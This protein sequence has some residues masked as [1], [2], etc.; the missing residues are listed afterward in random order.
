MIDPTKKRLAAIFTSVVVVFNVLILVLSF[1]VLHQSL[2]N[3]VKRHMEED[4]RG[5]FLDQYHRSGLAPLKGMWDENRF[6]ILNV[7]G[8]II[9]STRNSA[10]FYPELN[11]R[12]LAEAFAG[13]QGFETRIVNDKA[14]LIT[15]FPLD[16]NYVGRA[17][18]S[19]SGE[20]RHARNFLKMIL[21][22]SPVMLLLSY[23]VSRYLLNHAMKPI[24]DIVT[25]QETFSSNVTHELRSPLASIKGNFEVALR[26]ERS[27]EEYKEVIQSGLRDTDR[28][29]NLLNNLSLLA[30]SKFKPLALYKNK[31]DL[32]AIFR[33]LVASYAPAMNARRIT[34]E[35]SETPG[36][37]CIC[38]EDLIRRTMENLVDNA[39]KYT[40][41]GGTIRLDLSRDRGRIA[42]TITNTCEPVDKVDLKNLLNPFYRGKKSHLLAEGKGLGLY[43]VNYIVRSHGG[44]VIVD[45]PTANSFSVTVSL[46]V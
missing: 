8:A 29:I 25:F 6:Q 46:P 37:T 44:E 40:P 32:N 24:S 27:A 33:E 12:L 22:T 3:G 36:A 38:D 14:Q 31:A 19:L 9:V 16:A 11:R 43:I 35:T 1:I 7:Q 42:F 26:K 18:A 2:M 21:I 13:K 23:F 30:S 5:E 28:I 17:A 4:I 41:A 15:Y 20:I 34:Y 39:V 10:H 45:T